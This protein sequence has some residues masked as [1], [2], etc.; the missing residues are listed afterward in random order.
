MEKL[1]LDVHDWINKMESCQ[2]RII[3]YVLANYLAKKNDINITFI[4]SEHAE[5]TIEATISHYEREQGVPKTL[6]TA[7]KW[8][9]LLRGIKQKDERAMLDA[10]IKN[11]MKDY[12]L[13]FDDF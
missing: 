11:N 1:I 9:T 5:E 8:A 6:I 10:L 2:S 7:L 13:T 3:I 12:N 4:N